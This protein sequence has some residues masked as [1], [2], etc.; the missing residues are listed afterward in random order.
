MIQNKAT[1]PRLELTVDSKM[2]FGFE[3]FM[4]SHW[5]VDWKYFS[6]ATTPL[7]ALD[8]ALQVMYVWTVNPE[9]A[10]SFAKRVAS[11]IPTAFNELPQ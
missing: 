11:D 7:G 6:H 4:K 2:W 8:V 5:G 3:V 10:E 9:L 1:T